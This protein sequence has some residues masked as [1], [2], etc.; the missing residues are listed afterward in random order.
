MSDLRF[1][2]LRKAFVQMGFLATQLPKRNAIASDRFRVLQLKTLQ[3]SR[4]F[5]PSHRLL[6]SYG[7]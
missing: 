2:V 3:I 1:R 6:R 7:L 4:H 5:C